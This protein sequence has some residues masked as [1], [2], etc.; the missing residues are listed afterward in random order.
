M[1]TI[2][3][4]KNFTL[5]RESMK[6]TLAAF[7]ANKSVVDVTREVFQ[8]TAPAPLAR[9]STPTPTPSLALVWVLGG[10]R[11]V[12]SRTLVPPK[13][14]AASKASPASKEVLREPTVVSESADSSSK[15]GTKSAPLDPSP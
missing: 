7:K 9:H 5:T 8:A 14:P 6:E 11:S 15:E 2:K 13:A 4:P 12:A 10:S 3:L 1:G